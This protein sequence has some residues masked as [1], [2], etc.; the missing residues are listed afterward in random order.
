[1]E[2]QTTI[3]DFPKKVRELRLP[4]NAF[5]KITL[6][7]LADNQELKKSRWAKAVE[8]I[9]SE[10]YLKGKSEEA[11]KLFRQFRDEVSF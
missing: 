1:M 7:D 2:I 6:S 9:R 11:N 5:I 8:R 10:D 3:K 4:P